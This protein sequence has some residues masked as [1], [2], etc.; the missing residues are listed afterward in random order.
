MSAALTRSS[1]LGELRATDSHW[2]RSPSAEDNLSTISAIAVATRVLLLLMVSR[3]SSLL[4]EEELRSQ[5]NPVPQHR[6]PQS[7][8]CLCKPTAYF[9]YSS[10]CCPEVPIRSQRLDPEFDTHD[11]IAPFPHCSSKRKDPRSGG[12]CDKIS[13]PIQEHGESKNRVGGQVQHRVS[14]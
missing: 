13:F 1:S 9:V 2:R 4:R 12:R 14:C 8:A 3:R 5:E 11:V 10:V 7:G 6:H